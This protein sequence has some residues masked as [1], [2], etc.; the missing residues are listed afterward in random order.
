MAAGWCF[1]RA[2]AAALTCA[3]ASAVPR[4]WWAPGGRHDGHGFQPAVARRRVHHGRAGGGSEVGCMWL[5]EGALGSPTIWGGPAEFMAATS[6][7]L[8]Q[9]LPPRGVFWSGV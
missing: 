5:H 7:L 9:A 8:S 1:S 2:P 3:Q 6:K 4:A